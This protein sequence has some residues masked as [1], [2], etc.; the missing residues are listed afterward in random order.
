MKQFL[1]LD[2]KKSTIHIHIKKN[3]N[4]SITEHVRKVSSDV[5]VR[6]VSFVEYYTDY[7]SREKMMRKLLETILPQIK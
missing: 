4:H 6:S 2:I 7:R 3:A 5:Y 1:D